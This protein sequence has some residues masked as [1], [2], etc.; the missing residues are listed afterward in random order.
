MKRK[1]LALGLVAAM[2]AS[3]TACGGGSSATSSKSEAKSESKAES[4]SEASSTSEAKSESK[5][6]TAEKSESKDDGDSSWVIDIDDMMKGTQFEGLTADKEYN[7]QIVVKAF[8]NTYWQAVIAGV[9][10]A[11]ADLGVKV[12][13]QGPNTESDI[14][15]QVN[16]LNTAINN[17][18]DGIGLSA[19]DA[20]AVV[21]SLNKA[22]QAGI[23]IVAF[24]TAIDTAPEGTLAA[25]IATDS[26]AAADAA[27]EEAWNALADRIA[28][29]DK[30]VR[31][32]M[33]AQDATSSNHQQRGL[34]FVDGIISRAKDAG[35]KVAVVGNDYFTGA[36]SDKGDEKSA[37]IIIE[38]AVPSQSTLDF[39]ATEAS[40]IMNKADTICM[41]GTGQTASEAL[42]QANSTLGVLGAD[43]STDM[44]AIGFDS[45]TIN[46]EK[47]ND[48][49][50]YGCITQMPY[51]MGYYTVCALV[52]LANGGT[53]EDMNIP[54][55]FYN[56][57]NMTDDLI[58][59]NLYE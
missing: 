37:D 48:G 42:I 51:A 10:D 4:T 46:M 38:C 43:P 32:G 55:F 5:A 16:M 27:A 2:A 25:T 11:A 18:P 44:I 9:N 58:A 41:Y 54:G 6:E 15:D 50:L 35:Y 59:P 56:S 36:C 13:P 3:L 26:I 12:D 20:S 8:Q 53:V 21:D 7:F 17:S 40:A 52:Q 19:S 29:A 14:A 28:S 23:P 22:K 45:G 47:I 34:G 57:E 49:T 1:I 31:F 39:A 24:D 30:P 33:V